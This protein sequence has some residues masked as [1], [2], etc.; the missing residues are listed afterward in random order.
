[1]LAGLRLNRPQHQFI[2]HPKKFSAFVG[3]YRSGKTFVGCVRLCINAL[4]FPGIPQG[5]FAPTYPH[6]ADI[7]FDTLPM[8]AEAFGLHAEIIASKKR[9]Y[10]YN[11]RG[12]LLSE[13]ICKSM[14]HPGR[15]VGFAIAHALVDEIDLMKK[16][17]A[18][19]A[20]RKIIAR[21]S[22]IMLG[23]P[24]NTVDVTTTPE[25][26]NFVHEKFV[27]EL[28]NDPDQRALYGIVHASTRENAKNLPADYIQ[29]LRASYPANL[30]NAYIEGRFVNMTSG[31]VYAAFDRVLNASDAVRAPKEPLHIG[32]DFNV[33]KMAATVGVIRSGQPIITDEIFGVADT[34]AM[35]KEIKRRFP[36]HPVTI[37]PDASGANTSSK[38][39]SLSDIALLRDA[40]FAVVV[41][42][43]NPAVKDRIIA[44]NAMLLNAEGQ[45]R[46]LVNVKNCPKLTESLEQQAYNEHGEP[47]KTAGHDHC[48]AGDTLVRTP[49]GLMRLDELPES[50]FVES[51][52][53]RFVAYRS[54]G[55]KGYGDVMYLELSNGEMIKCTPDHQ[56]LKDDGSWVQAKNLLAG[57]ALLPSLRSESSN[58]EG[59]TITC[60]ENISS[61]MVFG[62]IGLFG[63]MLMAIYLLGTMFTTLT[64]IVRTILCRTL[65]CC[66]LTNIG[67]STPKTCGKVAKGG[68]TPAMVRAFWRRLRS[69][70]GPKRVG[71]GIKSTTQKCA[72]NCTQKI[73]R[74][75]ALCVGCSTRPT[76]QQINSA[77]GDAK[78]K[79]DGFLG[80]MMSKGSALSA[81]Q[82]SSST[83]IPQKL[84]AVV[85]ALRRL[86]DK[87]YQLRKKCLAFIAVKRRS[88]GFLLGLLKRSTVRMP[89]ESLT[90]KSIK[91][92][93][94]AEVYCLS[95]PKYGAFALA[96]G[97]VVANCNDALGYFIQ[98]LYPVVK[99][100]AVVR[101][102]RI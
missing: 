32:M 5:Y 64:E 93:G 59:K 99:R 28:A 14:E 100:V 7:F 89:V 57:D 36:D 54:A 90:I 8:V 66:G 76:T 23:R 61:A 31:S 52:L 56:L 10:L 13:I 84:A 86:A 68:G 40:K 1:M 21:M 18:K 67:Q 39:A 47:D 83:D 70:T 50:G 17:K 74:S 43:T 95:V 34:P 102:L 51:P 91:M 55:I 81:A 88:G 19:A 11:Q 44:V 71:L 49:A 35:I 53:G 33:H 2:T 94:R 72:I 22:F 25:G 6:I 96:N 48:F 63:W 29:S 30:V 20:W 37:Y 41:D 46:L 73:M 42:P 45:R 80:L 3:G 87:E 92:A 24:D 69:G 77:P 9:V 85:P 12:Q 27:S 26:F 82:P 101:P 75:L 4:E 58:I 16:A 79:Q 15:I 38:S 97:A 60:A 65:H 62:C 78:H 98:K